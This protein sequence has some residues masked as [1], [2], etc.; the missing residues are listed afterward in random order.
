M[1]R[2]RGFRILLLGSMFGLLCQTPAHGG[3]VT[4]QIQ[5]TT[6]G[7]GV[8]NGTLTF[9]L[10]QAAVVSGSASIAT[11]PVNC[12]TDAVGK[13][14][15]L[16]NPLSAPAVSTSPGAGLPAG[17][18][19]VRYTWANS[20]GETV[21]SPPT[22][23]TTTSAGSLGL[24]VPANPPANA[25]QWKIYIGT[26]TLAETLQSTQNAPFSNYATQ[27]TSLL[28]GSALPIA[29][30]SACSLRFND[31]LQPSFTGYTVTL[32]TGSGATVPGFPQKWYLAGG[33][34]GT[35]DVSSGT[36]LYQGAVVYP[37]AI[38]TTPPAN[39]MQSISGPLNMNGFAIINASIS[40]CDVDATSFSGSDIVAQIITA[41]NSAACALNG[42]RIRIPPNPL[43]GCWVATTQLLIPNSGGTTPTQKTFILQGSG[44]GGLSEGHGPST[45]PNGGTCIDMRFNAGTC[46]KICT[47]GQGKLVVLDIA[48]RDAGTD[49]TPFVY[50]TNT[51]IQFYRNQFYGNC[52]IGTLQDAF[53]LGGNLT[54]NTGTATDPY[55]GYDSNIDSNTFDCVRRA[56]LF[57]TFANAIHFTNNHIFIASGNASGG[58]IELNPPASVIN[59]NFITNNLI[60]LGGSNPGY[61]YGIN[62][63]QNSQYNTITGNACYDKSAASLACVN[64]A[65]GAG[66]FGNTIVVA[67]PDSTLPSITGQTSEVGLGAVNNAC[68]VHS[69]TTGNAARCLLQ[70]DSSNFTK[71]D[72]D[73]SGA[74]LPAIT[75]IGFAP[76]ANVGLLVRPNTILTGISQNGIESA[77][78]CSSAATGE[79]NAVV[80]RAD[81]QAAS[82]TVPSSNAFRVLDGIKGSGSTITKHVGLEIDNL[83]V[84]ATNYA[85]ETQGATNPIKLA[86]PLQLV[87]TTAPSAVSGSEV[88][89]AE[90]TSHALFCSFNGG[91]FARVGPT[92]LNQQNNLTPVVGN[93][94]DQVFFTYTVPAGTVPSGKSVRVTFTWKHS[95]GTAAITYKFFCGG[96]VISNYGSFTDA[97][98]SRYSGQITIVNLGTTISKSDQFITRTDNTGAA[99]LASGPTY[100]TGLVCDLSSGGGGKALAVLFNVANTD[101]VTPEMFNVELAP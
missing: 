15:G 7:R 83:T 67:N 84:G 46:G 54:T 45:P 4:G 9:T 51:G 29:N 43:G 12:F 68:A 70:F 94:A 53:I 99:T 6:S 58:A 26:S 16:P 98:S 20:S 8:S 64:V 34:L 100:A 89:Y 95:T 40:A 80:A 93:S 75:G 101:Q 24:Q 38:V 37:Q 25:T 17:T 69:I 36:P 77:P 33:A 59:G 57:Q 74:W 23:I 50:T 42:G 79:C 56:A 2:I 5:M 91:A 62:L 71:L 65:S 3:T 81:T 90:S 14:V 47:F 86:G 97:N 61:K 66:N 52:A 60:E 49:G 18:Y 78:V 31:E 72:P 55:Q 13:V 96:T 19:L 41:M 85:I 28:G 44:A 87:E 48:W 11:S 21:A 32:T 22:V 76:I 63:V 88:C 73:S 30:N 27:L 82:F 1:A 35:V 92:L 39:A 10:T